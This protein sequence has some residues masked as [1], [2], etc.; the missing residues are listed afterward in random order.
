[1]TYPHRL[2]GFQFGRWTVLHKAPSKNGHKYWWCRCTC[3]TERAV[4]RSNLITGDS[5]GCGCKRNRV[6]GNRFRTHGKSRDPV[7]RTWIE[8][9]RRKRHKNCPVCKEWDSFEK[10][11]KDMGE[12]PPDTYLCRV[13]PR[14]PYCIW[15]CFWG[16]KFERFNA[17]TV[18]K[19]YKYRKTWLPL[20]EI[21]R[22]ECR[23]DEHPK[24]YMRIIR[25]A[26]LQDALR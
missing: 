5:T 24:I 1:M 22:L 14:E 13:D 10:F 8:L 4:S 15:N 20:K 3:G 12:Q 18:P 16:T 25:G 11:Y 17:T 26:T 19:W 2:N 23:E 7:Y 6:I 21:C 9:L